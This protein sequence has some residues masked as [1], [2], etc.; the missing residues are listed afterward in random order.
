MLVNAFRAHLAEF[1]I[2]E[3][4]GAASGKISLPKS[5]LMDDPS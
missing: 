5:R 4:L 3:K 1:G 2:V